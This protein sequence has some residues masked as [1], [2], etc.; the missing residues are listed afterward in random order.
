MAT[1][2]GDPARALWR[3]QVVLTTLAL[4]AFTAVTVLTRVALSDWGRSPSNK[5]ELLAVAAAVGAAVVMLL[6]AACLHAF[7]IARVVLAGGHTTET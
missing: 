2:A 4:V 5:A 7:R 1:L 3:R 6:A